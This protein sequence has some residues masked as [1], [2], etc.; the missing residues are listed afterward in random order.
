M[1]KEI[2]AAPQM[3]EGAENGADEAS[4]T[5]PSEGATT[6]PTEEPATGEDE[7]DDGTESTE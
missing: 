7:T 2:K 4:T 3:P 1:D 6:E 5:E